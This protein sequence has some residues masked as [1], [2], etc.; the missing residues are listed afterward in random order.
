MRGRKKKGQA[1][2]NYL[3]EGKE[4][5]GET[6]KCKNK[7][8]ELE[9]SVRLAKEVGRVQ[10]VFMCCWSNPTGDLLQQKAGCLKDGDHKTML[11]IYIVDK[12]C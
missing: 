4:S 3:G 8:R 5:T 1:D 10:L 11:N 9:G 2:A 6:C 7:G 12:G